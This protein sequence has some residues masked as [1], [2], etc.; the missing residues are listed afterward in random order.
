MDCMIC[1]SSMSYYFTKNFGGEFNLYDVEY[2]KC[3]GCGF[4]IS[5]THKDMP[6]SV[7][8]RLNEAV[9]STYQ[10]TDIAVYDPKWLTRLAAQAKILSRLAKIKVLPQQFPWMDYAC[11]DGKLADL[12]S[13]SGLP[14][15]KFDRYMHTGNGEYLTDNQ[16]ISRRYD[17]VINTS[18]LEHLLSI[19]AFDQMASLVS[20]SGV[21][22]IHTLVRED[23]PQDPKWFYLLPVHVA[24]YTNRS[25]QILFDNY[26]FKAS[27]YHLGS[28]MWFWFKDNIEQVEQAAIDFNRTEPDQLFF[29]KGFMDYWK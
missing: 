19:D 26:G 28:T 25:M 14:T 10:G 5:K 15:L 4:V 6:T 8:E 3:D 20:D 24:F 17:N 21:L 18:V 13:E 27:I 9:H 12:L 23:I 7:W 1:K 29:K 2:W 11:G 16:L 22:S